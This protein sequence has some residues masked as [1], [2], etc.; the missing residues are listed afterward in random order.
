M[1]AVSTLFTI[2]TPLLPAQCTLVELHWAG[3][4]PPYNITINTTFD[5]VL[6]YYPSITT[7]STTW[8]ANVTA[9][10]AVAVI[11][12]DADGVDGNSDIFIMNRGTSD[13]CLQHGKKALSTG[14]IAVI[15]V[16]G[17]VI[18]SAA[19]ALAVWTRRRRRS[20]DW[21]GRERGRPIPLPAIKALLDARFLISW[22]LVDLNGTSLD[23]AQPQLSSKALMRQRE[24]RAEGA[25]VAVESSGSRVLDESTSAEVGDHT[26]RA[27]MS[28]VEVVDRQV[29]PFVRPPQTRSKQNALDSAGSTQ[30][31]HSSRSALASS[32][33]QPLGDQ[34]RVPTH[35]LDGGVR[36]AGG[37]LDALDD[38]DAT[39]TLP[40]PYR[41]Y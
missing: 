16:A 35:A 31:S 19:L 6:A 29:I 7:T 26:L 1:S 8:I 9:G 11:G 27:D 21:H 10:A 5:K 17:A 25:E 13:S 34:G 41:R 38:I 33:P 2:D 22:F 4:T 20:G 15:A 3:G 14:G 32:D 23:P 28:V 30:E 40:P 39:A 36:L 24:L 18:C 37:P 12:T